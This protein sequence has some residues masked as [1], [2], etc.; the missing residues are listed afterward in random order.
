[1]IS[2]MHA[3]RPSRLL[4]ALLATAGVCAALA[5]QACAMSARGVDGLSPRLLQLSRRSFSSLPRLQQTE[6]L[7]IPMS[8]AGSLQRKGNRVLVTVRFAHGAIARLD[9]L[10]EAGASI[11]AASRRYQTVSVA[12]PSDRLRQLAAAPGVGSVA[13]SLAPRLALSE[14][15]MGKAVS[16]GIEQLNVDGERGVD[17]LEGAGVKVGVLSDSYDT[18][19]ESIEEGPIATKAAEDVASGDLPGLTNTCPGENLPV[20]VLHDI[21]SEQAAEATDEGRAMLQIVHDVAPNAL[22]AFDTAHPTQEEFASHIEELAGAGADV[23]VDDVSYFEEPFF[24]EGPVAAAVDKV[25][26]EGVSYFSAAGNENVFDAEGNEIGSWEAERFRDSGGCPVAV[27]EAS[28]EFETE[29]GVGLNPAH[30]MDFN[31]GAA[32]DR[33][34]GIKVPAGATLQLDLQWDEPW[35]GVGTDLDAFLLDANGRLLTGSVEDNASPIE[36]GGTQMPF[37]FVAWENESSVQ[38]TVQLVINRYSGG[39]PRLKFLT[40]GED[41]EPAGVE[42]P[43]SVGEDTAGPTVFGH[44]AAAGAI[45]VAALPFFESSEPEPYSSRGPVTHYF[46]AVEGTTPAAPLAEPEV[47]SSPQVTATDCVSTTFFAELLA[48][49]AWHFCGTSAAAP[50]AAGVAA[51]MKGRDPIAEPDEIRDALLESAVPIGSFGDCAVGA[52]LIE[53]LGAVEDL[54]SA[55]PEQLQCEPPERSS[56][57][58][59]ARAPGNWGSETPPPEEQPHPQTNTP[60]ATVPQPVTPVPFELRAFI[61][62]RPHRVVWT[63]GRRAKVVFRFRANEGGVTFLCRVDRGRF[64]R[65]RSRLVRRLAPGRHVVRLKARDGAGNVDSTAAVYRFRVRR[66]D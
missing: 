16:E 28:R 14:C 63:R 2:A 1:M 17:P 27:V 32:V 12:V 31:P 5:P 55:A 58:G 40:M 39:E 66:R 62:K 25:A 26:S 6:A 50:H 11:V 9:A 61:A 65:C 30:C 3:S 64:H 19:T 41:G 57:V 10:R 18:A 45:G 13:P 56:A 51:L 7:G 38:K 20:E 4:L 29:F 21:P 53:A 42:Y 52:G 59:N 35:Y 34:F 54:G 49:E 46:G 24:Q 23:I 36:A 22:L 8:G 37:E 43:H 48:D 60:P 15:R 47:V 33:T 44:P